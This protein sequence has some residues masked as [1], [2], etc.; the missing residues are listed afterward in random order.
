[1][2]IVAHPVATDRRHL[3]AVYT[4]PAEVALACAL[5]VE[6]LS[7][8]LGACSVLDPA[9]GDGAFL[10][11]IAAHGVPALLEGVDADPFA[12][13]AART[14]LPDA[15]IAHDDALT[16]DW[17]GRY[18][19]IVGNPPYVRH[20][21]LRDPLAR[22]GRYADTVAAA[23][24]RAAPGLRLS[25]RADLA[26]AF[27]ALG[28]SLL[29]ERGVLAFV[30]SSAWLDAAYGEPLGRWLLDQGLA[31]LCERPAERTFAEADVNSVVVVVQRGETGPVAIRQ[32]GSGLRRVDRS[33]LRSAGKW[34]GRLLRAPAAAPLL[35]GGMRLGDACRVASYLITGCD[36]FFYRRAR[37]P[38]DARLLRPAVKSTRGQHEIELRGTPPWLLVSC[39]EP[40]ALGDEGAAAVAR[41]VPQLSGVRPRR[42]WSLIEQ[43]P[44]P[45]LCV[46]TARDRHLAYLNPS[47][48]ASGEFYRVWPPDGVSPRAL[49][50]FLN[51]SVCG[52]QLEALGRAYGGGG[53]P[54]KVERADLV[55]LRIPPPAALQAAAPALE[56]ALRPLLGRPIGTVS[57]E[58]RR[59]DRDELEAICAELAG[60]DAT[61]VRDAHAAAVDA[62]VGRA[63][64]VLS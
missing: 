28:V 19:L 31:E 27:L 36:S 46:R 6:R 40:A 50:A 24:A 30:T 23:V 39:H 58:R 61:W 62:R 29:A 26:C 47:G 34:G 14:S 51:S 8:P 21:A 38:L 18:D 33:G 16:R 53:G 49:A 56:Q 13:A 44:A 1:V 32:V 15:R 55:E 35:D 20:Q 11:G 52:L 4:P 64:R 57:G 54:L 9:C 60:V 7:R 43:E 41:G 2:R 3:G 10:R 45:V 63:R 5:A 22:G 59:R 48:W 17:T 42:I 12:V 37:G 25:G